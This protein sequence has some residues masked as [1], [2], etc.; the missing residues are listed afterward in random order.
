MYKASYSACLLSKCYVSNPMKFLHSGAMTQGGEAGKLFFE[1]VLKTKKHR[2]SDR[3]RK[4]GTCCTHLPLRMR[5]LFLRHT[6]HNAHTMQR[7]NKRHKSHISGEWG[8]KF[9]QC[10]CWK[11][12]QRPRYPW[13]NAYLF[14]LLIWCF[15]LT[16][17]QQIYAHIHTWTSQA[18][19]GPC[20]EMRH[21][22]WNTSG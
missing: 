7:G 3:Q 18:G 4:E 20:C 19:C 12:V 5:G 13:K 9:S 2:H 10:Q 1:V 17:P 21:K 11:L 14:I 15:P 22:D 6:Q 16:K 8:T